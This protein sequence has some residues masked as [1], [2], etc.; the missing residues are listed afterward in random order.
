MAEL[1]ESS[2]PKA[3]L[4]HSEERT[5]IDWIG[6]KQQTGNCMSLCEVRDYASHLY[7]NVLAKTLH[8]G[9]LGDE[10]SEG[11]MYGSFR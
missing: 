5:V 9:S 1:R 3:R 6:T 8:E 2:G 10:S 7:R 11:G 4:M